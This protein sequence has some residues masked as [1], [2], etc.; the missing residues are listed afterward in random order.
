MAKTVFP[1]PGLES[2]GAG[3]GDAGLDPCSGNSILHTATKSSN[4]AAKGCT[5]CQIKKDPT[6][7]S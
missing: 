3:E 6:C 1:R 5:C 2:G 4:A 7:H